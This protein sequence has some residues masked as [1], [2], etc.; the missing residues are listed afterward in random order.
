MTALKRETERPLMVPMILLR[1]RSLL[2]SRVGEAVAAGKK[3]SRRQRITDIQIV[4]I[5]GLRGVVTGKLPT[6]LPASYRHSQVTDPIT[7]KLPTLNWA[8]LFACPQ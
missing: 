1:D 6:L 5:Q 7:G 2:V 8:G 4:E 3:F